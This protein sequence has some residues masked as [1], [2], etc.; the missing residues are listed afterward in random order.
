MKIAVLKER[1]PG[2]ARVAASPDMVKRL[3]ALGVAMAVEAGAGVRSGFADEALAAA[4]ARL[5]GDAAETLREARMVF[6]VNRPLPA[7]ERARGELEAIPA[8]S[9]LI[10][11]LDPLAHREQFAAYAAKGLTVLAMELVPR[12]GR[13][14]SV[15][16][17]SSQASLAGYRAVL[18][19]CAHYMR[20]MPLMMTAAGTLAPARVLV[21]GAGVAG[22]QAIATARRLGAVVSAFDVRAAAR[23]QVESLG[24]SFIEVGGDGDGETAAGYAREMDED[25]KGRQA[26][27]IAEALKKT[28][29]CIATAQIPGA[30][31][32]K[33][34]TVAMVKEMKPGSVIVDLA[35]ESGG[36]C[37]ATRY[38]EVANVDGVAVIGFANMPARIAGAA[39]QLYARNL[40]N[41]VEPFVERA[42]GAIALD[43]DDPVIAG[44]CAMRDGRL[45]H[46]LLNG[47]ERE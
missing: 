4:G 38:D 24:G 15:D 34:V 42:T 17:L 45:V 43:F 37:E 27:A 36:N 2:E 47:P 20:A 31:A 5:A 30:P 28:D 3:D 10:G 33:L 16:A 22:L 46:P 29:I 9:T 8:G 19:A 13:A 40:F 32:P 25:Y 39:S 14:Q 41:L 23:E 1:R 7:S 26:L 44:C 21:L 12:I 35:T 11:M 6:K 18:D